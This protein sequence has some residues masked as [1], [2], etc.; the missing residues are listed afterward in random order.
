MEK[1]TALTI[2]GSDSSGGAG[3]Q[4][5]LKAFNYVGVHGTTIITCVTAQHPEQVLSIYPLPTDE[6]KEQAKAV[7]SKLKPDA[8]KIGMLYNSEIT[9]CVKDLLQDYKAKNVVLDPVLSATSGYTLS[10]KNLI[11]SILKD[12][13]P[14]SYLVTPNI[15]EAEKLTGIKI[16]DIEDVKQAAK[17][18]IDKGAENV[19]I[20]GGH[21]KGKQQATDVLF[22]GKKETL[23]SLPKLNQNGWHGSGCMLSS[24][25]TGY[26]AKNTRLEY[27]VE[28]SKHALWGMMRNSYKIEKT[29]LLESSQTITVDVPPTGLTPKRFQVWFELNKAFHQLLNILPKNLI[30]EVGINIGYALP[31]AKSKNDVCAVDGR[32]T[33]GVQKTYHGTLRFGTSK[34]VA[35]II[36]AAM[37]FDKT[38]RSAMNIRYSQDL[39][40]KIK[41]K[42]LTV[43]SFSRKE[44]PKDTGSTM[45]WG[46]TYVIQKHGMVPDVIWDKG[47]VGKE[48]MIR[49]LGKNP[50]TLINKLKRILD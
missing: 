1:K 33:K 38:V 27:A 34:H 6:I 15:P 7:F 29:S 41:K 8:T 44:E 14:L 5:D 12:V 22:N 30:P 36:L 49:I 10:K 46:T 47:A 21:L 35:S 45:E 40:K 24:L 31:N 20:K 37:K 23:I 3:I 18:L 39:I 2:A 11:E 32:I 17:I 4:A 19:L 48:P 26:L 16:T 50:E 9:R 42:D 13:L 28:L 25:I 43:Y